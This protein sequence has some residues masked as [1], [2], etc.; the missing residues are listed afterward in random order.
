[1]I[2]FDDAEVEE[3]KSFKLKSQIHV[4]HHL[5]WVGVLS[6]ASSCYR[7]R[8][9][10]RKFTKRSSNVCLVKCPRR[11]VNF[12]RRNSGC[13][14]RN[15][16]CWQRSQRSALPSSEE[17]RNNTSTSL[18][19]WSWSVRLFFF[20]QA[21]RDHQ[22]DPFWRRVVLKEGWNEGVKIIPKELL[23]QCTEMYQGSIGR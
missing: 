1:M 23:P 17:N 12:G 22:G 3:W 4:D 16:P 15:C 18:F 6:T 14:P 13:F 9:S 20:T 8:R 21:R 7:V 2:V 11:D 5:W 10:I 19:T